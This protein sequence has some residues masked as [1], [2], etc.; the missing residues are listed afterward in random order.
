[1]NDALEP[2]NRFAILQV[3]GGETETIEQIP[4]DQ[5]M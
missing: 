5:F 1:M 4:R 2:L 3:Q